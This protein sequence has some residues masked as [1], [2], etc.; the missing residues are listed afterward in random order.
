[1]NEL[2]D[3]WWRFVP[4]PPPD[5]AAMTLAAKSGRGELSRALRDARE[6][7]G[8]VRAMKLLQAVDRTAAL[9]PIRVYFAATYQLRV[10]ADALLLAF[11]I[12]GLDLE[13]V[14]AE[15][16]L[17]GGM[18]EAEEAENGFDCA[19]V[20]VAPSDAGRADPAA[21]AVAAAGALAARLGCPVAI[22]P[23][24]T[25]A[26][27]APADLPQ[28]VTLCRVAPRLARNE[29][30]F[31]ERFAGSLGTI[32]SQWGADAIAD[33]AAGFAAGIAGRAPKL[34]VTDLDDTLWSGVLG[35]TAVTRLRQAYGA[36]LAALAARGLVI[37]AASRNDPA[38]VDAALADPSAASALPPFASRAVGWE[39]KP[40]LMAAVLQELGLAPGHTLFVDDDPVNCARVAA[41]FP[42]MDVR[43]FTG[44]EAAFA[45]MLLADPLLADGGPTATGG[46]RWAFYR[47]RAAVEAAR[48][49]AP[50]DAAF[51]ARLGTRLTIAAI[52]PANV[53]RAAE[54][55][56]RVNQFALTGLRPSEIALAGRGSPFDF[57]VRLD[58]VFG[59]HGLVGLVLARRDGE[60]VVIDNLMLSCRAL[61]RRV[62]FAMLAILAERARAEGARRLV[63]TVEDLERNAPARRLFAS[64]GWH[65]AAGRWTLELDPSV[66]SPAEAWPDGVAL[67]PQP[68]TEEI[69]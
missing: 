5:E 26:S 25:D 3:A 15:G 58:D 7:L 21:A 46:D 61:Q 51:L 4:A 40:T 30:L 12:A 8:V 23:G 37:A 66:P 1:M 52:S 35:E 62:E 65:E 69:Q 36:A 29:P 24:E 6:R 47:R 50:D 48:E 18:A 20:S 38:A 60:A 67:A 31:D 68:E 42:D 10:I 56:R 45:A 64:A 57:L 14:A 44:D 11:A 17:P 27:A 63:G 54:L 33:T 55:A 2:S 43:R 32:P 28:G 41:R 9:R 34:L 13:L 49:E 53:P 16:L 59:G 19:I 39:D 22:I